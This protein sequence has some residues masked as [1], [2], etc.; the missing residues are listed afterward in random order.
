MSEKET[1]QEKYKR[2]LRTKGKEIAR[3]EMGIERTVE[4]RKL[5]IKE[6]QRKGGKPSKKGKPPP[7]P[8]PSFKGKGGINCWVRYNNSGVRYITCGTYSGSGP[9]PPPIKRTPLVSPATFVGLV[10][11]SGYNDLTEG[12]KRE[13]HRLVMANR[14][15]EER[16]NIEMNTPEYKKFLEER[17]E[18][19]REERKQKE[20]S[21]AEKREEAKLTRAFLR[22]GATARTNE[23]IEEFYKVFEKRDR[24][25]NKSVQKKEERLE[26]LREQ[27]EKRRND[28]LKGSDDELTDRAIRE[29]LEFIGEGGIYKPEFGVPF[30]KLR[31]GETK[32]EIE[33][34][35]IKTPF[36]NY[37]L[38]EIV[39]K[40]GGTN[41][42]LILSVGLGGNQRKDVKNN[43]NRM[44]TNAFN[45]V[46]KKLGKRRKDFSPKDPDVM[47]A[48][49]KDFFNSFAKSPYGSDVQN[50]ELAFKV[51]DNLTKI[52]LRKYKEEVEEDYKDELEDIERQEKIKSDRLDSDIRKRYEGK[53]SK[54][55]DQLRTAIRLAE[56]KNIPKGWIQK[57]VRIIFDEETG[58]P[59]QGDYLKDMV[60]KVGSSYEKVKKLEGDLKELQEAVK[61]TRDGL[62]KGTTFSNKFYDDVYKNLAKADKRIREL[63]KEEKRLKKFF[64]QQ[65]RERAKKDPNFKP[66]Q[67]ASIGNVDAME[68][69][70]EKLK[71][72]AEENRKKNKNISVSIKEDE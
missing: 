4:G 44:S 21:K 68:S 28:S 52:A 54:A 65:N 30:R 41:L 1:P 38:D 51:Q 47:K 56:E 5:A 17:R 63:K 29:T 25:T 8:P 18:D 22:K 15:A 33:K 23:D 49:E 24:E 7:A 48:M 53:V 27:A 12:Q 42:N 11:A 66:Q 20:I 67:P 14:R 57:N 13:Y 37:T 59:L 31:K 69:L 61:E 3:K 64:R 9:A 46:F 16:E 55:K 72:E 10:G 34:I 40:T 36:G 60:T 26:S 35:K 6:A 45:R 19:A 70:F 71:K 39:E 32:R 43:L 62:R 50:K 2:L 58:E